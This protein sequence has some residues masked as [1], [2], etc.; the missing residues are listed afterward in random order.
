MKNKLWT[1]GCSFTESLKSMYE[2][3]LKNGN[4]SSFIDYYKYMGNS[5]PPMWSELLAEK[6][7]L[8]LENKGVGGSSNYTILSSFI[9]NIKNFKENDLIIIQWTISLRFRICDYNTN[10]FR[11][12]LPMNI[13]EPNMRK[14]FPYMQNRERGIW[15]TEL[16]EYSHFIIE[17]C[18]SKNIKLMFW[19]VDDVLYSKL[20]NDIK[21]YF[22]HSPNGNNI[23][24][25]HDSYLSRKTN[26]WKIKQETNH[27]IDDEHYGKYGNHYMYE[28]LNINYN[29]LYNKIN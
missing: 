28:I 24:I 4:P 8:E 12:L 25:G 13:D 20:S 1:F 6:L 26:Q 27:T 29:R 21:D 3:D 5:F 15:F 10:K 22:I 2:Q 23:E 17:Y 18:K 7:N 14:Y 11:D 16:I 19:S 9:Q